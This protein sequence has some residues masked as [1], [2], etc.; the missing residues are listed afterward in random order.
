MSQA[1]QSIHALVAGFATRVRPEPCRCERLAFPHRRDH[2]CDDRAEFLRDDA[3]DYRRQQQAEWAADRA[4][5]A[6]AINRGEQ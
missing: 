5:D 2:D 6:N 1:A 4:Q 3:A